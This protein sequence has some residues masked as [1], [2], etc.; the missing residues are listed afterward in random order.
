MI[1]HF[2]INIRCKNCNGQG[3]LQSSED[4]TKVRLICGW[5]GSV[6]YIIGDN[7]E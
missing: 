6:E 2:E 4:E 3:Y 5:C 7:E 1:E